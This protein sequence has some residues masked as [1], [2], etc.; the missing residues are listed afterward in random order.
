[1]VTTT[2]SELRMLSRLARD[3]V[4]CGADW[5]L[6]LLK[7]FVVSRSG[8]GWVWIRW[9]PKWFGMVFGVGFVVNWMIFQ[10]GLWFV[11]F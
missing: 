2:P 7:W 10:R 9:S 3:V 11:L 4:V 5:H 1:M 8:S 6:G